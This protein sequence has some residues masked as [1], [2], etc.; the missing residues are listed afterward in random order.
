M[1]V[2]GVVRAGVERGPLLRGG[3]GEGAEHVTLRLEHHLRLVVSRRDRPLRSRRR[4]AA[5]TAAVSSVP[6]IYGAAVQFA[7]RF[8]DKVT[9]VA[10]L[11]PMI[12]PQNGFTGTVADPVPWL[13]MMHLPDVPGGRGRVDER[14][15]R[16]GEDRLPDAPVPPVP[17]FPSPC[18]PYACT[19]NCHGLYSSPRQRPRRH[20]L[21]D[22]E[23]AACDTGVVSSRPA[24]PSTSCP[25]CS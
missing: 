10:E 14:R 8:P 23:P 24:T 6:Y 11:T 3:L 19:G 15:G 18:A 7:A 21:H 16:G 13:T 4:T 1:R 17:I 2:V 9:D 20:H 25:T 22:R 5:L 12:V